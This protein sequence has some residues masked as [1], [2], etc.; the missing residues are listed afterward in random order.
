MY[1]RCALSECELVTMRCVWNLGDRAT[2]FNVINMLAED[3]GLQYKETT[4]YTFLKKLKEK[5][6][7][8]TRRQGVTYYV[9]KVSEETFQ[10]EMAKKLLNFWYNGDIAGAVRAVVEG[11]TIS[12]KD[13]KSIRDA[14]RQSNE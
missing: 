4:V 9:P 3:Y 2:A 5:G 6:F 14:L 1:E 13:A 12:R 8:D 11:E 10:K 7:V